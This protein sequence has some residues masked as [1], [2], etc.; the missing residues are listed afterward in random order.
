M[1]RAL[2]LP[3]F[4]YTPQKH[5]TD[6]TFPGNAQGDQ[7]GRVVQINGSGTII[8]ISS[9]FAD[10]P[11][12]DAGEVKVYRKDNGNQWHKLGNTLVGMEPGELF[13]SS[14]SMN[15]KG[16]VL[17]IGAPLNSK[18]SFNS[19]QVRVYKLSNGIWSPLGN[20]LNG[21]FSNDFFGTTVELDAKGDRLVV[22]A[23][24]NDTAGE[25]AGYVK[26]YELKVDQWKPFGGTLVGGSPGEQ[27][28]SAISYSDDGKIL[29]VASPM[30]GANNVV[31]GKVV[32]YQVNAKEEWQPMG[33]AMVGDDPF[34]HFGS[35]ICLNAHGSLLA[36]SAPFGK[37][38]ANN[39]SGVVQLYRLG[40]DRAEKISK[41]ISGAGTGNLIGNSVAI[42]GNGTRL[43]IGAPLSVDKIN[44]KGKVLVCQ[45]DKNGN[46]ISREELFGEHP[47]ELFG[48]SVSIDNDGTGII[49][50]APFNNSNGPLSGQATLIEYQVKKQHKLLLFLLWLFEK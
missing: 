33:N 7:R 16:N 39:G 3:F 41:D 8:A 47:N 24:Y 35:S 43:A 10:F 40:K 14:V 18:S 31:Y 13:G 48:Q 30:F 50:G 46:V 5:H 29:A 23:P 17:A 19:G 15:R 32:V 25:D 26:T 36:V 45:L 21:E 27:A 1:F 20:F 28:G 37:S 9:P 6:I 49:V 4:L 42:S 34:A 22:G 2:V 38:N 11:Y 12:E 44:G